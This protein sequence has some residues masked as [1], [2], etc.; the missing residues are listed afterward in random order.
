MRQNARRLTT[1][2]PYSLRAT[3]ARRR[4]CRSPGPKWW[5]RRRPAIRIA[6]GSTRTRWSS[7]W[8][9]DPVAEAATLL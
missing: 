5:T 3:R 7:G 2:A 4:P 9:G 6:C 8:R 1:V